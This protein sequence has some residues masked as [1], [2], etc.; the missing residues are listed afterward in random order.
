MSFAPSWISEYPLK[1]FSGKRL[2]RLFMDR[3]VHSVSGLTVEVE[4]MLFL[5]MLF[6][7]KHDFL[8]AVAAY[9]P[10]TVSC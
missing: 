6:D 9:S 3:V 5:A 4:P 10:I 8:F 1:R 2:R 7:K